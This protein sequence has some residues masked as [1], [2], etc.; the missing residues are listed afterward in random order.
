MTPATIDKLSVAS[1]IVK[2]KGEPGLPMLLGEKSRRLAFSDIDGSRLACERLATF[3]RQGWH[4]LE[5]AA[6]YVHGWHI[7]LICDHLEAIT[8]GTFLEQGLD[9][10]LLVNVPPGTMKSL[11][12]SVFWPAWEWGPCDM[13]HN[14]ILSTSYSLE[15]VKRDCRRMRDLILSDWYQARWGDRVKLVRVGETS[16][17]NTRTGSREGV[18]FGSLTGGRGDRLI[19]DDPHSTET[20]ESDTERA[21]TIRLFRESVPLRLNDQ[22]KSAIV[23]IMQRLHADDCSGVAMDLKLGY[24]PIILPMEFDSSRRCETPFGR[25]PRKT[26]GELLFP[27]RFPRKIVDRDKHAMGSYAVA[28]Q[29]Q[30][31]PV[32]REGGLFKRGWFTGKIVRDIPRN[33]QMVR[34]WDLASTVGSDAAYTCGVKIGRA[35]GG[36]FYVA[37]VIRD[38]LEGPAVRRLIYQTAQQDGTGVEISLP[39]DPGQAGKTQ[40]RDLIS[41]LAGFRVKA[42]PETGSKVTRAEPFA[43]QCEGGNVYLYEAPWNVAYLDELTLFPGGKYA[44]Q[45]D[46]SS[47]A[48]G[49]LIRSGEFGAIFTRGLW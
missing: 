41:M 42:D 4:V 45:V 19:I 15:Y 24:T 39:Q 32:P 43:S 47:G 21:R 36:N 37:D 33:L 23:L 17:S 20:A 26:E 10:R 13:P 49:R 48:F 28:G 7:D 5:P 27:E 1:E 40:A 9:N 34:H 2:A 38:R 46:A 14:R 18:P 12:V 25:D 16:F 31:R 29:L 3:V 11:L 22:S 6:P 44:D 35:K 8:Y 30:Q